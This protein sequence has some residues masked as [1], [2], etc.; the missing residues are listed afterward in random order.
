MPRA[1]EQLYDRLETEM[2][3]EG[4]LG[5]DADVLFFSVGGA[6]HIEWDWPLASDPRG[7]DRRSRAIRVIITREL[8][9]MLCA[10]DELGYD[11]LLRAALGALGRRMQQYAPEHP[12]PTY[13]D[14]GP[15][16]IHLSPV[17]I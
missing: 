11:R 14:L 15:F 13:A 6:T 5:P 9:Y 3:R 1:R 10:A 7:P 16:E 2:R 17:N 4:F 8:S 12:D